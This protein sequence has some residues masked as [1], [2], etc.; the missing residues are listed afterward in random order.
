MMQISGD[1][2]GPRREKNMSARSQVPTGAFAVWLALGELGLGAPADGKPDR[3]A[4]GRW[5]GQG[6][7][8]EVAE[9]GATL[10]YDCAHG[11]LDEAILLDAEGRFE[12]KGLHFRERG[13]PAREGQEPKGQPVRYTGK[14]EGKTM[15][16][17]IKGLDKDE[18]IGTYTLVHAKPP[19]IRRCL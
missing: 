13:G 18:P 5:G 2:D 11:T 15:T 6:I 1:F 9:K 19:R 4:A 3:V 16:L 12:V 14:V 8:M 10:D 7:A 17:T